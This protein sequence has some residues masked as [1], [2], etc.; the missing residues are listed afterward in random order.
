MKLRQIGF[1]GGLLGA[2]GFVLTD[3]PSGFPAPAWTAAGI[4][5]LMAAWWVTE[6]LPL[7]ATAL[8]PIAAL[9]L[10]GVLPLERVAVPYANPLIFLANFGDMVL[11]SMKRFPRL[12]DDTKPPSPIKTSSDIE[13]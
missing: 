11:V 5:L 1:W 12:A 13:G 3:P 7:A 10:L 6:A 9:P 4:A 2:A 8:V